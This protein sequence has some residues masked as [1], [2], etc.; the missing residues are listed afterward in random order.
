VIVLRSDLKSPLA[1]QSDEKKITP[2]TSSLDKAAAANSPKNPADADECKSEGEAK[3]G[4][5]SR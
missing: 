3:S 1:P 5:V 2:P 4:D